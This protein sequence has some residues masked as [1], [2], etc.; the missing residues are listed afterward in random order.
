MTSDCDNLD[1]FFDGELPADAAQ[2]FRVHLA[3]C[4][5]CQVALRGRMLEAVVVDCER[6]VIAD[7]P[8]RRTWPWLAMLF[9]AAAC[10]GL[11]A[12]YAGSRT[13][14][15]VAVAF[16]PGP[17][18]GP[19]VRFSDPAMDRWRPHRV[20]RAAAPPIHEAI[21]ISILSELERRQQWNALVAAQALRGE[22]PS[23]LETAKRL[24]EDARSLSD[25]A[26]LALLAVDNASE[27]VALPRQQQAAERALSLAAEALRLE[28]GNAQALW[29]RAIALRRL[30]LPLVGAQVFD[31]IAAKREPGWSQEA[32]DNAAQL[33]A[34]HRT[35]H[36]ELR[37]IDEE[38]AA[39]TTGGPVVAADR[40]ELAPSQVRK[41]LYLAIATAASPDRLDA[42][43][44]LARAIDG[45]FSTTAMVAL[46]EQ[47]RRSDLSR[48]APV[49]RALSAFVAHHEH[50][51]EI[52]RIRSRAQ[53]LG[54]GDI[55]LA[56]FLAI[57][58][59]QTDAGDLALLGKLAATQ[60]DS[61]WRV[62]EIMRRTYNLQYKD[63]DPARAN[64]M[65]RTAEALCRA[66]PSLS[67]ERIAMFQGA[68][69]ADLGRLDVALEQLSKAR[70]MAHQPATRDDEA[71]TLDVIAQ[72]MSV[73]VQDAIDS[74][75][76][77][78]A[79]FSEY[80][81]RKGTCEAQLQRLDFLALA[82]LDRHRYREAG[83][84]RAQADSLERGTCRDE[85]LR[86]NGETVR[87][88]LAL[89]GHGELAEHKL[90]ALEAEKR[91]NQSSYIRYLRAAA[92]ITTDRAGGEAALRRV[93]AD[94]DAHPG[95]PFAALA[96]STAY[97]TL[98]EVAARANEADGVIAL[99]AGQMR[100]AAPE[101][102]A[103]GIAQWNQ[104]AVAVRGAAGQR[105]VETR[106][107]PERQLALAP[108]ELVSPALRAA[109][110]GCARV[111]V[112]TQGR[113]FGMA[114]VLEPTVAWAYKTASP[115]RGARAGGELVVTDVAPPEELHL[116]A[117][118]SFRG[119]PSAVVLRR[120]AATPSATLDKMR[121]AGLIVIVAHGI[122][123]TREP[124]AASL[125]LSPDRDGDYLLNAAKVSTARLDNAPIVVLAGCHAGRVQVSS[126]PWSLATAFRAAGARAVIAP[127]Q[128]IPDDE[129]SQAFQSLVE[130]IRAGADPADALR[131]ER[132]AR[133]S[134]AAWLSSIVVFD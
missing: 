68:A 40:A 21:E 7:A 133:G 25:R 96:R 63:R 45:E 114:G 90:G 70:Q 78:D 66:T 41:A 55:V 50:V 120:S 110:A 3:T 9:P 5:H 13:P 87:L 51:D 65:A 113:Y 36:D 115:A 24:P 10:A 69:S 39:M 54:L 6:P 58:D 53:Q 72:V 20:V 84:F 38:A 18:R 22:L 132:T 8:R 28:P 91:D 71:L 30:Q 11:L 46:V 124:D 83:A 77:S 88:R 97:S 35:D 73:R 92:T 62:F 100:V 131:A 32:S 16:S 14:E 12:W 95:A 47:V 67:C 123:D 4:S 29:N 82:A 48:R 52:N 130:N 108:G 1:T 42:L 94:A 56:S 37:R 98:V 31:E 119:S 49:A 105:A 33:R 75:A 103:V 121:T 74:V 125:I 128:E 112:L 99:I 64:D 107:V 17:E 15:P 104:V 126:D 57:T 127:T 106:E 26:A 19:E 43:V 85:P 86:L 61:W 59:W 109:L 60:Q 101:R 102:C 27:P 111:E 117:L 116:P 122:T 134:R 76:L 23:A 44:P 80:A 79:Y 34:D 81:L 129:A 93:I 118:R 2:K 89:G